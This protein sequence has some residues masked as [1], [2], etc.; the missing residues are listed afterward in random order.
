[1]H[2]RRFTDESFAPSIDPVAQQVQM[3]ELNLL[4]E[5]PLALLDWA[6]THCTGAPDRNDADAPDRS[7]RACA[8]PAMGSHRAAHKMH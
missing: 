2:R 7:R 4:Q 1:M 8:D 6:R 3:Q 5:E